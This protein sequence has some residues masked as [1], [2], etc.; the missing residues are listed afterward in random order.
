MNLPTK[1]NVSA[2][3]AEG[4]EALLTY[5]TEDDET[6]YLQ[7]APTVQSPVRRRTARTESA[8]PSLS[9]NPEDF[10][11]EA[12]RVFSRQSFSGGEGLD[13]AHR[14][15]SSP[16]DGSRFWISK[17][18][19]VRPTEPG[20]PEKVALAKA[21][22]VIPNT[23]SAETTP[24]MVRSPD[25][26]RVFWI[27]TNTVEYHDDLLATTPSPTAENPGTA[28]SGS[29]VAVLDLAMLGRTLYASLTGVGTHQRTSAGT[30]TNWSNQETSRVWGAKG[31]VIGANANTLYELAAGAA[32][33]T[34]KALTDASDTWTAVVDAGTVILAA[35]SDGKIYAFALEG[36]TLTLKS[37]VP[38]TD[39][40][41]EVVYE[42]AFA[43]GLLFLGVGEVN[44]SSGVT[45]RLYGAQMVGQTVRNARLIREFGTISVDTTPR[46]FNVQREAVIF[47]VQTATGREIWRYHLKTG[48]VSLESEILV[49]AG[50]CRSIV[51][52]DNRLIMAL[53]GD[54]LYR[55]KATYQAS[56]YMIFP[57][58][59]FFSAAKKSWVGLRVESPTIA[60]YTG[61]KVE[62]YYSTNIA[63]LN[64]SSHSSWTAGITLQ[65]SDTPTLS[66][67]KGLQEVEGRYLIL[68]L[69][70]TSATDLANTPEVTSV[71]VRG[72]LQQDDV[73]LQVP[74]NVSDIL[75][76]PTKSP[77]RVKGRGNAIYHAIRQKEGSPVD[78]ELLRNNE[79]VRGRLESIT[80]AQ[81][82]I[83]SRGTSMLVADLVIR[84]QDI[85]DA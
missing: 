62:L 43:N 26:S 81:P 45:G 12:G 36:G 8:L 38:V 60:T 55:E 5:G 80:M 51:A 18:L 9:E 74:V 75:E 24:Y 44:T 65:A 72:F 48:G 61:A 76:R 22:E 23:A 16:R 13:F 67:E 25:Q 1:V 78:L 2:P 68:K 3:A 15:N 70:I 57:A 19:S 20:T 77:I 63:A 64:D 21:T 47:G 39:S 56:G 71:A 10:R 31:R 85:T 73:L 66:T 41:V 28:A 33:T 53:D 52:L 42:M 35:A 59:D 37:E 6:L 54:G 49:T 11:A 79:I 29:S 83:S 69:V 84:G 27:D 7:L 46:G 82:A 4:Y 40:G 17:G 50:L 58:A 30:W 14:P 34:L 32:S